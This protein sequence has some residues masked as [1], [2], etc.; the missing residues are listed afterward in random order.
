MK[1][2]GFQVDFLYIEQWMN[3]AEY[4]MKNY[5]EQA[6]GVIRRGRRRIQ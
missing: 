2:L 1:H 3:E 4:L 6:E 5:E